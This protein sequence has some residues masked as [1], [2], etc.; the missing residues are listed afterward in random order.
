MME[1]RQ[2]TQAATALCPSA[3]SQLAS[4]LSCTPPPD[5]VRAEFTR[6]FVHDP[7]QAVRYLH[8]L[9]QAN[10]YLQP[11]DSSR[12]IAWTSESAYGQLELTINLSK[13]EK[14]PRDI[15]KAAASKETGDIPACDLCWENEEFPGV[16]GHPAKPGLRIAAI[17]LGG[18]RWGLQF[19]PYAYFREHCI[20][21]SEH[22]RPMCIEAATFERLLDFV[23]AFPFYFIGSNAD[24]PIVGGSI[25]SHDHFQGGRHV[26]SLM[27][28][29]IEREVHLDSE[30]GVRSGV[31]RWPASVLRL[32][33][34]DREA[35]ARVAR[36]VLQAWQ[37][38][39]YEPCNIVAHDGQGQHNTINPIV[40]KDGTTYTMD[41]VLR[42]NRTDAQ[43]PWGIFH[44]GAELHHIKKENIGLIEIMGRAI[45]PP[46]LAHELVAVQ[47][48]LDDALRNGWKAGVLR[49]R[50]EKHADTA[51]HSAWAQEVYAR[52]KDERVCLELG[53][54]VD[55]A[56]GADGA[57]R[58]DD[59]DRAVHP[60]WGPCALHPALQDEVARVF[61]S[62]LEACGVFKRTPEGRKGW[63]AF[64]ASLA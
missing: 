20:V 60:E 26:F 25:L 24:L 63:D 45:L 42:N 9:G 7:E 14:D 64:I 6:R 41:I 13:P 52:W 40:Y 57:G 36:M 28:A 53:D 39:S 37:A 46:R 62:I 19:S 21:L 43:H 17:E 48:E 54:S 10:G 50:L 3:A 12:M 23:D 44:P 33:S 59:T 56:V 31:V 38:F 27:K 22:H 18:E 58:V 5:E 34:E 15:A 4:S 16:P 55:R 29:P 11:E 51:L 32:M 35:L 47:G 8:A 2:T 30:P 61:V 49:E 1:K